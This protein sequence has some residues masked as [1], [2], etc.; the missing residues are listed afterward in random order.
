M[1]R[2]YQS[3]DLI[4]LAACLAGV[5][6]TDPVRSPLQPEIIVVP[7]PGMARW[8]SLQIADRLGVCA[9]IHF[10][11]PAEYIWH[12]LRQ[13]F[14]DVPHQSP[15]SVDTM[16]WRIMA[17]LPELINRPEFT[18]VARYLEEGDI[19]KQ[20]ELSQ[21]IARVFDRYLVYRPEWVCAWEQGKQNHWQAE[22]WRQVVQPTGMMHWAQLLQRLQQLP[23]S[24][25]PPLLQ[26]ALLFAVPTLSPG[27]IQALGVM[28]QHSD[29]H[30]FI[31]NP[32]R[33]YW[34]DIKSKREIIR[35]E[36]QSGEGDID[37]YFETGNSLL[38]AW[39]RE[40]R[41][42]LS[43][44]LEL[45]TEDIECFIEYSTDTLLGKIQSDILDLEE[46]GSSV[47]DQILIADTD[48][49]IKVEVVHSAMREV[50]VL[51]D[52]LLAMLDADPNIQ[53][54]DIVVMMPDVEAYAPHIDA[55]FSGLNDQKRMPYRIAD[56][57][58]IS[59][60]PLV[61]TF[62]SLLNL[63]DS[64]FEN[65]F[66]L[67]LLECDALSAQF[68][69]SDEDLPLLQMFIR[70]SGIRWGIDAAHRATFDLPENN[71]HSW[72]FGLD[73]LLLGYCMQGEEGA[74][75]FSGIHPMS[76]IEGDSAR[77]VA[78]LIN[79]VRCLN[80]WRQRLQKPRSMTAW[81][82]LCQQL[83]V[84][85]FDED[86]NELEFIYQALDSINTA[87]TD[88]AFNK[89]VKLPL[90]KESI[91]SALESVSARDQFLGKGVTFCA[92]LPMRSMPFKVV[93][94]IGMQGTAFPRCDPRLGF[95]LLRQHPKAGDRSARNEDRYLFLE[96]LTAAQQ[97]F[98]ISYVGQNIKD[99]AVIPP[100]VLVSEL[101][102]YI[103]TSYV[104]HNNNAPS[105]M[106]VTRH[107]LQGFSTRYFDDKET[108]LFTYSKEYQSVSL[109]HEA[110][111]TGN[112]PFSSEFLMVSDEQWR[113]VSLADLIQFYSMPSRYLLK[114]R[115]KLNLDFYEQQLETAEPFNM[116]K[117]AERQL[118][119]A[120]FKLNLKETATQQVH[121]YIQAAGLLP[122]GQ[123][124]EILFS[125]HHATSKQHQQD[126]AL[127][128]DDESLEVIE[129]KINLDSFTLYGELSGV[130]KKGLFI[131]QINKFSPKE[132]LSA[133]LSHLVLNLF[134]RTDIKAETY[135]VSRDQSLRFTPVNNAEKLL[136]NLLDLYWQGLQ[137]PLKFFPA[138]SQT[139]YSQL[140]SKRAKIPPLDAAADKWQGSDR[141]W[142][143]GQDR[144]NRLAFRNTEVFDDEFIEIATQI[145]EPLYQH[146]EKL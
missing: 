134:D 34:D 61:R 83:L 4:S 124:G 126:L 40:G 64:R 37:H 33:V 104:L 43:N 7:N 130:C 94:L 52:Q 8:L 73:R 146:M 87:V 127:L 103:D 143:E 45:H 139:Y 2:T 35:H 140:I 63:P 13:F 59:E 36:L 120:L 80:T 5:L 81:V 136:I 48:S 102:D 110:Q 27:Y 106:L 114:R 118:A 55:V 72:Q 122:H 123:P 79:F 74:D 70:E 67:E 84:T 119:R 71:E 47:S 10:Q 97:Y 25:P 108:A 100:C 18:P 128:T 11:F 22:L 3:N 117:A 39:G 29:C 12:V 125:H 50:E 24:T 31:R 115:L 112:V 21:Q 16:C 78:G 14:S 121:H 68:S 98:Y 145:F 93:C 109:L 116:D 88:S 86:S 82:T 113:Q 53:A 92:L 1:F 30:L 44:V 107:P 96:A 20:Y 91:N 135:L 129:F 133:W 99:N 89:R 58:S 26:R 141:Y 77:L 57:R 137:S 42:Y 28:G 101:L 54:A 95:D 49:S 56:S 76:D 51:H 144:Y 38:A 9:N 90:V 105:S 65:T 66:I 138:A 17:V 19:L 41:E 62:L 6:S 142:G 60:T 32:C 85:F 23:K 46:P 111:T 131:T 15:L 132:M 69:F 75:T